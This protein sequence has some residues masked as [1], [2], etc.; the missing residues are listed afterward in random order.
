VAER[1]DAGV[2]SGA[3]LVREMNDAVER[4]DLEALAKRMHPDVVWSHNVGVGTIEEGEY[5]GRESVVA[6]F[7]RIL[8]PWEYMR[9]TP[10][11]VREVGGGVLVIKGELQA[12]HS[13]IATE[14][15][16]PYEQRLEFQDG[17]LARGEMV[18]GAG[19][20]LVEPESH[21]G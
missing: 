8:E 6:L 1:R 5:K 12:K 11:E 16:T 7:E 10:H 2:T 17:L 15:V 19:A 14:I 21:S 13:T 4:Q 9:A 18:S 20:R 3:D